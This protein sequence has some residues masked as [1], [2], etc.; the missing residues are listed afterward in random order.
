LPEVRWSAR[1]AGALLAEEFLEIGS[2]GRIFDRPEIRADADIEANFGIG[3]PGHGLHATSRLFDF[4]GRR[5][6]EEAPILTRELGHALIADRIG[7]V[8]RRRA[9]RQHHAPRFGQAM[10]LLELERR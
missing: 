2:A 7:S 5:Q 1:R 8:A 6:S 10:L 3:T 4:S 9:V